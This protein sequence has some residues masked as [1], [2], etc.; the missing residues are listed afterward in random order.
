MTSVRLLTYNIL[1]ARARV[2][3]R[4]VIKSV[5]PDVLLVNESPQMPLLWRW[6]A[7]SLAREWEL[8]HIAG[9]RNAG[10]NMVCAQPHVGVASTYVHRIRAGPMEAVRGVV[11]AQLQADSHRFGVVGCHLGI[12]PDARIAEVQ[13]VLRAADELEGPVV[14]AGDLNEPPSAPAWEALLDAGFVDHGDDEDHTFP[15]EKPTQRLDA[16]LVRGDVQVQRHK[17]PGIQPE[18]MRL[19]SDHLPVTATLVWP[20]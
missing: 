7:P 9:G 5:N 16:L 20:H 12:D 6:Q 1:G 14:V 19:A 10:R 3:L 8:Q 17:I 13:D 2:A 18:L 15:A 11:S 4:S